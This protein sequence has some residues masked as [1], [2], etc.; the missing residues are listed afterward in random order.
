MSG[1]IEAAER[2]EACARGRNS[3]KV[4]GAFPHTLASGIFVWVDLG[5][6][7]IS[8]VFESAPELLVVS[9]STDLEHRPL[10]HCID[11]SIA[12]A[13][14]RNSDPIR[15]ARADYSSVSADIVECVEQ[16]IERN[17]R[18]GV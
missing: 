9:F 3:S 18:P 1:L 16:L 13:G 2:G 12:R 5:T 15:T 10:P 4:S 7:A 17:L 11:L 6:D 8:R 14:H